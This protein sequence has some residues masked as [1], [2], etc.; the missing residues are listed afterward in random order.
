NVKA[1]Q[2]MLGHASAAMTLGVY[3]GLFEDD[4]SAVAARLD[5]AFAAR[6]MYKSCTDDPGEETP[7]DR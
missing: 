6:G 1:V 3:S 2:Q 7:D 5:E 4:L